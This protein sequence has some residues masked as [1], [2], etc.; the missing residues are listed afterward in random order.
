VESLSSEEYE[1]R[2]IDGLI[3]LLKGPVGIPFPEYSS[4]DDDSRFLFTTTG[5]IF[6]A[7]LPKPEMV[8]G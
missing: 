3:G 2:E 8:T 4:H 5:E 7:I 6:H 1:K